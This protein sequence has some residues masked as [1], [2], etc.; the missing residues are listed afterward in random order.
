MISSE[1]TANLVNQIAKLVALYTP[2]TQKSWHKQL[3]ISVNKNI[4]VIK[5]NHTSNLPLFQSLEGWTLSWTASRSG[6]WRGLPTMTG[7]LPKKLYIPGTF[8][9]WRNCLTFVSHIR[10]KFLH[11]LIMS[12]QHYK[13]DKT[14]CCRPV[15][16]VAIATQGALQSVS[17]SLTGAEQMG[18]EIPQHDEEGG[19]IT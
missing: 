18:R 12:S 6:L 9:D 17:I 14:C 11:R 13:Y 7:S 2:R 3:F 15:K 4:H 8:S 16:T 1:N 19:A 5:R 10:K